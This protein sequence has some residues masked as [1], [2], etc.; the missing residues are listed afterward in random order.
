M[1]ARLP[2][3][4]ALRSRT[5]AELRCRYVRIQAYNWTMPARRV[6]GS[7]RA[8]VFYALLIGSLFVLFAPSVEACSI[9]V[10]EPLK[11][12]FKHAPVAFEGL[13]EHVAANGDAHFRVERL[14]KGAI[15]H[16]V[17]I[18]N[19]QTSCGFYG[20]RVGERYVVVPEADGSI[21]TGSHV[22]V[23]DAGAQTK[24]LLDS[25]A[26]WWRCPLSSFA[27]RAILRSVGKR[28]P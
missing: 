8:P 12:A 22:E 9:T 18:R 2:A 19:P 1:H 5:N 10:R 16:G 24:R 15:Q 27:P 17:V 6:I 23:A 28:L 21:H 7:L 25:R 20:L 26:S 11:Y 13:L 14:W 4:S 3:A